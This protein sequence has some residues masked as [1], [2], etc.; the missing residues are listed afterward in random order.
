MATPNVAGVAALMLQANPNLTPAEIKETLMNT[1][2][3]LNGDYSVF[4]SG[5]G[6]V[7]PYEA[8]HSKTRIEVVDETK[9]LSDK[10]GNLKTVKDLTG[11]LAFGVFTPAG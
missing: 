11:A 2:D 4:E 5:A 3:P 9:G 6:Q 8:I 1:A 10:K 7:D